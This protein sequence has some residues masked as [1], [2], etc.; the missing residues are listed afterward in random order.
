MKQL[1]LDVPAI[2]CAD[3]LGDSF[4]ELFERPQI[5]EQKNPDLPKKISIN[6]LIQ[7][8]FNLPSN[9]E[10]IIENGPPF[11]P[12]ILSFLQNHRPH[13]L[14]KNLPKAPDIRPKTITNAPPT[15]FQF[16]PI[17]SEACQPQYSPM[18]ENDESAAT[19]SN[20]NSTHYQ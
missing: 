12:N 15:S 20:S 13:L 4:A 2:P 16:G 10:D 9:I 1:N 5:Q 6:K 8:K 14:H 19:N 18:S 3:D 11:P 7:K 17:P